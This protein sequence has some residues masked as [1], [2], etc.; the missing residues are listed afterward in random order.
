MPKFRRARDE[1]QVG[2]GSP[3]PIRRCWVFARG[4]GVD[5]VTRVVAWAV[6]RVD[7]FAVLLPCRGRRSSSIGVDPFLHSWMGRL[8]LRVAI[9]MWSLNVYVS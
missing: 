4:D 6:A 9:W 3:S 7:N 8:W 5:A 2:M 1:G